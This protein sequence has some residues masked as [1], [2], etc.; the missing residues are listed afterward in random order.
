MRA[1]VAVCVRGV[2]LGWLVRVIWR[3][4]GLGWGKVPGGASLWRP[5]RFLT[6]QLSTA[7]LRRE[8]Y[9]FKVHEFVFRNFSVDCLKQYSF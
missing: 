9:D 7:V 1:C 8:M 4:A 5:V 6:L 2:A 3:P